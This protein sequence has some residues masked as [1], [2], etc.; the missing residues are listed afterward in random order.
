MPDRPRIATPGPAQV[1]QR[2]AAEDPPNRSEHRVSMMGMGDSLSTPCT[3]LP[4]N[5]CRSAL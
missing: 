3:A 1:R 4:I 5:K 2:A